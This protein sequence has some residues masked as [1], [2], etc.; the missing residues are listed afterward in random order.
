MRYF[1][2]LLLA[3]SSAASIAADSRRFAVLSLIGDKLMVAQ[4]YP[5]EGFRSDGSL[6]A[7][8]SLDDNAFDKTALQAV[9]AVLKRIDKDAKPLLLVARDTSLYDAQAAVAKSGQNSVALLERLDPMLRGSGTTHL[10][11]LT[12]LRHEARVQQLKDTAL[13]SG[14]LEGIGYYLDAGRGAP[15]KLG[16]SGDAVFGP[17]AY[18]RLELI[19]LAARRIVKE[20]KVVASRAFPNPGSAN[21]WATMSN[22]EKILA[23]QDIIRRET[24]RAVPALLGT[25]RF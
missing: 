5:N 12:K 17:F 2:L 20:E 14:E 3:L 23:L 8:V 1:L 6:Q 13:G 19:D 25:P 9:D 4:Y 11:L 18:V 16:S 10:I 7:L 21:P 22:S 15:N 24:S